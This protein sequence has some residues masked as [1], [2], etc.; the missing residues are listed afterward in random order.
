M[1][2]PGTATFAMHNATLKALEKL[3]RDSQTEA[4]DE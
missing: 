1:N 2:S 4:S 3:Q